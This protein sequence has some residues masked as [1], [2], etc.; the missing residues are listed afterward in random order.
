MDPSQLNLKCKTDIKMDTTSFEIEWHVHKEVI[1]NIFHSKIASVRSNIL[2]TE[3][4]NSSW[5]L[6]FRKNVIKRQSRF[7]YYVGICLINVKKTQGISVHFG[8]ELKANKGEGKQVGE[9]MWQDDASDVNFAW[10]LSEADIEMGRFW[11]GDFLIIIGKVKLRSLR[12][13]IITTPFTPGCL[14]PAQRDL[15]NRYKNLLDTGLLS[16]VTLLVADQKFKAH[17]CILANSCEYFRAMFTGGLKE[18]TQKVIEITDVGPEVF[19]T[20]LKFIYSGELPED[21]TPIA[22]EL[23]IAADKYDLQMVV[24]QCVNH[25]SKMLNLDTCVQLLVFADYY[26]QQDLKKV[27]ITFMKTNIRQIVDHENWKALKKDNAQLA[28]D[29]LEAAN[30]E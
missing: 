29:V 27:V 26:N 22:K 20:I 11:H 15:E 12:N 28:F 2:H 10:I 9:H 5:C 25:L 3:F 19:E 21:L 7:E 1:Q 13:E 23:L 14:E 4:A 30:I 16:D 24:I 18:S 6:E 17:R 8:Y